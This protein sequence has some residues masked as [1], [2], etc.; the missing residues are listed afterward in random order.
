MFFLNYYYFVRTSQKSDK[1]RFRVRREGTAQQE[2][3]PRMEF[4]RHIW[5]P[6]GFEDIKLLPLLH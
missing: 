2:R 4:R 6:V 1:G 5:S 3:I